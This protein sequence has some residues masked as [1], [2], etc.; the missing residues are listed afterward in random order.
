M[1]ITRLETVYIKSRRLFPRV[2]TDKFI[3]GLGEPAVEGRTSTIK[4]VVH[5]IGR[6]KTH[7]GWSITGRG[8]FVDNSIKPSLGIELHDALA[9]KL[10]DGLWDPPHL[11]QVDGWVAD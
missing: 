1:K 8:Y 10:Y 3:I 9:D 5:E 7:A 11:R 2:H 6:Y 4:A